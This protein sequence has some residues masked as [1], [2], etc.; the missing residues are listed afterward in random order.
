[1]EVRGVLDVDVGEPG[2]R[3]AAR[4]LAGKE[5]SVASPIHV[6]H[7]VVDLAGLEDFGLPAEQLPVELL[8][9]L[10]VRRHELVPSDAADEGLD[11]AHPN[12][13]VRPSPD[14]GP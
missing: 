13:L 11:S 12:L 5:A 1:G 3:R 2:G 10:D 9:L 8:R 4:L 6:D 14:L 7:R